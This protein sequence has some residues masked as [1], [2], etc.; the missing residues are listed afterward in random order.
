[1]MFSFGALLAIGK[2]YETLTPGSARVGSA[3]LTSAL[4]YCAYGTRTI[5]VVLVFALIAADLARFRRPNRFLVAVLALTGA[6]IFAQALSIT[7]AKGYISV[8]HFSPRT[9]EANAIYYG[10]TLSYVWQNGYEKQIQIVVALFFTALAAVSFARSLWKER[11]VQEFYL[12]AYMTVLTAW[13]AEIGLRGLLPILPLYFLYG[14]REV[15][16]IVANARPAVRVGVIGAIAGV[17]VLSYAGQFARE[18]AAA[19]EPDVMDAGAQEIFAFVRTHTSPDDTLVFPKP[20][21]LALFTDRNVAALSPDQPVERS[22]KF[23]TN[24][25]S[26]VLIDPDWSPSLLGQKLEANP[27]KELFRDSGYR[28]YRVN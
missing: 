28:I 23:I 24:I 9:I 11:G 8:F 6:F 27:A 17:A 15:S 4:I 20:R 26:N 22:V 12:L 18:R 2:T 5:G 10:K 1:L 16:R 13:N 14:F 25:R 19:A 21:S 7:A 3:L